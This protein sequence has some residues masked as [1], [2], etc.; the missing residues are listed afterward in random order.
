MPSPWDTY[1]RK[2]VEDNTLFFYAKIKAKVFTACSA[3]VQIY[4][5]NQL[6]KRTNGNGMEYTKTAEKKKYKKNT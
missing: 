4:L 1:R 2:I 6:E 5:G 3:I